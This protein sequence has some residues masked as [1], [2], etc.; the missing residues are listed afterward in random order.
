M[1]DSLTIQK[2]PTL[3]P[4]EDYDFLRAEG[5]KHIEKLAGKIWTDYNTHD[6]GIT[7]HELI[8]YAIT[9]LGYRTS[10]DIK[11]ILSDTNGEI[12]DNTNSFFTASQI[13]PCNP[14]SVIDFRKL[15]IDILGVKNAWIKKAVNVGVPFKPDPKNSKLVFENKFTDDSV[16]L[17]GIYDIIVEFED[18]IDTEN[19]KKEV[20]NKVRSQAHSHRNICEDINK[21]KNVD[22]EDIAVCAE[23]EVEQNANIN[24]ILAEIYYNLVE[25]FSPTINFYTIEELQEKRKTSDEIFEGPRLDHG[26]IDSDEIENAELKVEL[27]V[28]D[29][30]NFV[31]DIDGVKAVKKMM[32]TSYDGNEIL[33]LDKS[34]KLNLS[35]ENY[36]PRL[37]VDKSQFIFYKDILPYFA[38]AETVERKLQEL[39]DFHRKGK[40]KGHDI[41]LKIP[42]GK[43]RDIEDYYPVQYEF[44]LVYG[45][46]EHG[47]PKSASQKRKSQ[48]KQLKA[49]LLF[50]EQLLANY[51]SQLANVSKLFSFNSSVDKTYFSQYVTGIDDLKL[52][53]LD[54][55]NDFKLNHDDDVEDLKTYEDRRNRFLD[56]LLGRFCED[57]TEYG[58]ML[59]SLIGE[60]SYAKLIKDKIALL[61]EYPDISENR[62]RG[63]NYTLKNELW[64]TKNVAGMKKR[65][66]RLLGFDYYDRE[67]LT[68]DKIYIKEIITSG[69]SEYAIFVADPDD[70]TNQIIIL[71]GIKY[72]TRECAESA[73][74]FLLSHGDNDDSYEKE[75]DT[76]KYF[77]HL[78]NDCYEKIAS[79]REYQKSED[80]DSD[81]DK[82]KNYF[83][84]TID[85]ENFHIIEHILL[86]PKNK[87]YNFMPVCIEIEEEKK[88]DFYFEIFKDKPKKPSRKSEW[89]FRLKDI[90]TDII[91]KSEGY[92]VLASC[93]HGI[94]AVKYYAADKK[95]FEVLEAVNGKYYFNLIAAN[96]EI[97]GTSSDLYKTSSDAEK[98]VEKLTAWAASLTI[99]QE[100]EKLSDYEIDPYSYRISIILPSWAEIF[101]NINFRRFV[102]KSIRMETPAHLFPRICWI[103]W[104]QMQAFEKDYKVWLD[105]LEKNKSIGMKTEAANKLI[106]RLFDLRNVYPVTKLHDCETAGG[107]DPQVILDN[108]SLGII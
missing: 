23:I 76:N 55:E 27:R 93:E 19:E 65:I 80:R 15:F 57:I 22:Y 86:R 36:A 4:S 12:S 2:K 33:Q 78:L 53:Y 13:F 54:Y 66:C 74:H 29:I 103:D 85:I 52:L 26:F 44:P 35:K 87:N 50:F 79:S 14:V 94:K 21:I 64:D 46:G 30:I 61:N 98:V 105:P 89:R 108:T 38:N 7:I 41:D 96:F 18:N 102:E 107:D 60:K 68:S 6:P 39:Y 100:E 24:I 95:N 49:Y 17:K 34:W 31:M 101:R 92:T 59:Y 56:H 42:D 75:D 58:L 99:K 20:I 3:L 90:S 71:E 47:L 25:Y 1:S 9:D 45:I 37:S 84:T 81:L 16:Q 69:G 97:V 51:L 82:I 32:L 72:S 83:K 104:E 67:N 5:I 8:C 48:A 73:L 11:E 91:F 62:G 43:Y 10:F 40:L 106:N 63:F 28:S 88:E 70:A 77:F